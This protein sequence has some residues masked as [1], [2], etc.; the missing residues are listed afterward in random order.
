M[1]IR[2]RIVLIVVTFHSYHQFFVLLLF[3][4]LT[5]ELVK[6]L[7]RISI[8]IMGPVIAMGT[9]TLLSA[10]VLVNKNIILVRDLYGSIPNNFFK[11]QLPILPE[12]TG[13]VIYD[14]CYFVFAIV[15]VSGVESNLCFQWQIG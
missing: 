14:I 12:I 13:G 15:F 9:A 4:L 6:V 3:C 11:I 1:P 7:L 8:F 5:F 2:L 10:T